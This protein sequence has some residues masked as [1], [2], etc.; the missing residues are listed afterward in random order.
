[1]SGFG[2]EGW[3]KIPTVKRKRLTLNSLMVS[4]FKVEPLRKA[5]VHTP[6][7]R[8]VLLLLPP[9]APGKVDLFN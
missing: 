5:N 8:S 2:G 4:F 7:V 6:K 1:M 3:H 9:K